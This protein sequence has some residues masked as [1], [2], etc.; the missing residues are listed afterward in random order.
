MGDFMNGKTGR[1]ALVGAGQLGSRHLQALAKSD[2]PL[3]VDVI[4]PAP[5]ALEVAAARFGEMTPTAVTARFLAAIPQDAEYDLAI[6]ASSSIPRAG[7]VK[8]LLAESRVAN[9]VLEKFLFPRLDE[10]GEIGAL[11]AEKGVNAWVNCPRRMFADYQALKETLRGPL[12]ITVQGGMWGLASNAIHFVDLASWLAD[13]TFTVFDASGLDGTLHQSRRPG[14][15]ELSGSLIARNGAG[16][17]LFL[18]ARHSS[19]APHI[20]H[21]TAED[22]QHLIS[23]GDGTMTTWRRSA[24]WRP[25]TAAFRVRFQSELSHIFARDILAAGKCALPSFAESSAMHKGLLTALIR[26][27][28]TRAKTAEPGMFPV[29]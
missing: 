16:S 10:Y 26:L 18:H 4:D 20:V 21:I 23:E 25:E 13:E 14:Y 11:L 28:A 2:S 17:A 15:K 3:A 9:M 12:V 7:I 1:V 5:T 6:V 29:T 24:G 19:D 22:S 27:P 8:S